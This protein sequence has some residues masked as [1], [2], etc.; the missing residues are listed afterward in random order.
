LGWLYFDTGAMY[1]AITYLALQGNDELTNGDALGEL[2]RTTVIEIEPP[3]VNEQDGR[4]YTVWVGDADIT[5]LLREQRVDQHVSTVAAHP[6]VRTA[7]KTQQ[8]RIGLRGRVIM[9]GRDIGTVVLPEAPLKIYL[10][11]SVEERAHRRYR[12]IVARGEAA[13]YDQILADMRSRDARDSSRTTAPLRPAEDAIILN[14]DLMSIEAVAN[15]ILEY[16]QVRLGVRG[17]EK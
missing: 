2:A 13:D 7:L 15:A 4:Q 3:T 1:R 17:Q 16:A 6:A 9:V 14:S 8:R 11:A 10:D 12:E 5:W